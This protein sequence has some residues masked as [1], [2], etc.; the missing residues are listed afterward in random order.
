VLEDVIRREELIS[1]DG[2]VATF[3]VAHREPW[4]THV[5]EIVTWAGSAAVLVPVLAVVGLRLRQRTQ[6]WRPLI[7]LAASLAGAT[8][9]IKLAVGRPR[10]NT[11][12]L[13][14]ALGYA[15]P[16]GHATAATACWLSVAI[17][18]GTLTP[19]WE[20]KVALVTTALLIAA[21]VGL[22]RVYR[23]VHQPTDVL[24]GWALGGLWVAAVLVSSAMLT[25]RR[26]PIN[27]HTDAR[28]R[29]G[30]DKPAG[31]A[32]RAATS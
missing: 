5:F 16:S 11:G 7:F 28:P 24:G 32:S 6:T 29:S 8:A 13:V 20:R 22:S 15:F 2:P 30:A 12:A 21:I 9:L 25:H 3:V 31:P 1:I 14:D 18:L 19:R 23:G 27:E 26:Q 4:L 10:P 17:V